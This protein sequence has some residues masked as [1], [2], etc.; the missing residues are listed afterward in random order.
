MERA[1]E[2][3]PRIDVARE[4]P[5]RRDYR[6][7]RRPDEGVAMLLAAGQGAGIAAEEGKVRREILAKRHIG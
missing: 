3:E 4:I 6:L 2:A 5:G 1:V 7:E